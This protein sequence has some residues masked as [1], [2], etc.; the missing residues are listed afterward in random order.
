MK[1]SIGVFIIGLL[2][3]SL[4]FVFDS[5]VNVAQSAADW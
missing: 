3:L 2:A 4:F 1:R 5:N